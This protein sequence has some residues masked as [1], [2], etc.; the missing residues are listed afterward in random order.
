[1]KARILIVCIL[2]FSHLVFGQVSGVVF[3][4]Y[5]ANGIRNTGASYNEEGVGNVTVKA[6]NAAGA[7]VGSV[8]TTPTGAYSFTGLK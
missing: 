2:F 8:V 3:R 6:Y 4:D 7:E 5:N 1:M